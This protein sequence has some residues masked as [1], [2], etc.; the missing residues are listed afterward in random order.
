MPFDDPSSD[1]MMILLF[2]S[3]CFNSH[4]VAARS[5]FAFM[6]YCSIRLSPGST[7]PNWFQ[8]FA[9]C[10]CFCGAKQKRKQCERFEIIDR[11]IRV[12]GQGGNFS[13]KSINFV[14]RCVWRELLILL[15]LQYFYDFLW[16]RLLQRS[17]ML[18]GITIRSMTPIFIVC[19]AS[20]IGSLRCVRNCKLIFWLQISRFST[21]RCFLFLPQSMMR[22]SG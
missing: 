2:F 14:I 17:T 12:E 6:I 9:V 7:V 19:G 5:S 22:R 10:C 18:A 16:P 1:S 15:P 8:L 3:N 21:P 4:T 20:R 11:A 13:F